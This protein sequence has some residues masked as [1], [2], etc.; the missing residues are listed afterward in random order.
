MP[1]GHEIVC[2]NKEICHL[3]HI[4]DRINTCHG[5]DCD[6]HGNNTHQVIGAGQMNAVENRHEHHQE[7][8][9]PEPLI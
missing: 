1:H 7:G 3:P 9:H 2:K 8:I 6:T 4:Y 5:E